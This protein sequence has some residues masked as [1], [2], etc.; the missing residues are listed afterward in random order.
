MT[1]RDK[2]QNLQLNSTAVTSGKLAALCPVDEVVHNLNLDIVKVVFFTTHD[3]CLIPMLSLYHR[4]LFFVKR[5]CL[6]S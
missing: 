2:K 3:K 6:L 4:E 5:H 1:T